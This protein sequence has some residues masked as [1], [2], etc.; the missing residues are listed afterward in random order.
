MVLYLRKEFEEAWRGK[1]PFAE[2]DKLQGK[3]YRLVKTRRTLQFDLN[4]KSYFTKIHHGVGWAEIF[5]NLVQF[6]TTILGA[7]NEFNAIRKLE[8]LNVGTMNAAAFGK[9]GWNPAAQDSFIIT[10][11]I[12]NCPSL[13]DY[14]KTWRGDNRPNFILKL[15][16]LKKVAWISRQLH[17]NGIN[18]RDFY[19]C[20]FLLDPK[21][22]EKELIDDSCQLT[23]NSNPLST[24]NH[25]PSTRAL[26]PKL[27]VIDLHRAQI[28]RKTP[29]RWVIKDVSGLWFSAM[30]IGL[31][32]KDVFRFI[33]IYSNDSLRHELNQN[34]AF[35][36]EVN[37]KAIALYMKDF[38][39][40]P[41]CV[42]SKA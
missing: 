30:D 11:D 18:H 34:L 22:L 36:K 26:N 6:K 25:Q 29:H 10:D 17:T 23:V 8:S 15:S 12:Q 31:T 3:V 19:I 4:G 33:K 24:I 28:R 38:K 20:H 21:S 27:F 5:K 16:L 35:W 1:D 41:D 39:R 32:K 40:E 14:C 42:F 37:S 13:E 9:K 2:V 7:S